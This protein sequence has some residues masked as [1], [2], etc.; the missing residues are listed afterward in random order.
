VDE[1]KDIAAAY[2]VYYNKVEDESSPVGYWVEHTA[3]TFVVDQ[4]GNLR[5]VLPFGLEPPEIASDLRNLL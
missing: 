2:G 5:L 1:I 3:F 4:D